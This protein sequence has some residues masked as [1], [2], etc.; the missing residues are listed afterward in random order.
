[1]TTVGIVPG[2]HDYLDVMSDERAADRDRPMKA[3]QEDLGGAYRATEAIADGVRDGGVVTRQVNGQERRAVVARQA[4]AG[5]M[6]CDRSGR[7]DGEGECPD[8]CDA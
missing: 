2:L 3:G 7:E 6:G 8:E 4:G 1:M 5:G